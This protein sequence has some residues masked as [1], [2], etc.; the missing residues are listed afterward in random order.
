MK[1]ILI[2]LLL[3]LFALE[4]VGQATPVQ[5]EPKWAGNPNGAGSPYVV[6]VTFDGM[7][8]A[9]WCPVPPPAGAASG[10][11]WFQA[12]TYGGLYKAG[13]SAF[14]SALDRVK[15]APDPW[16]QAKIEMAAAPAKPASGTLDA[17]VLENLNR[18]ACVNLQTAKLAGYP[19]NTAA[20]AA[21]LCGAQQSCSVLPPAPKVC[22]TAT[23]GSGSVYKIT[24]GVLGALVSGK[25]APF[26]A[27]AD[28][29]TVKATKTVGTSV[30]TY[31]AYPGSAPG[32]GT[33][34]TCK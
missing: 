31:C 8:A 1:Q 33:L 14:L 27:P 23:S 4:A 16:A 21:A 34:V 7:A 24:N 17:C 13:W 3:G 26:G 5:C 6:E 30:F 32:E 11:Q 2:L 22:T 29:S 20:S 9:T 19:A 12:Y 15:K 10:T 28:C 25:V 18:Q